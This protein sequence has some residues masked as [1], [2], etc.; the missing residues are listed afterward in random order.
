MIDEHAL[1]SI[2]IP[3]FD[4]PAAL[5][6]T[7]AGVGCP[8]DD[9]SLCSVLPRILARPHGTQPRCTQPVH[10][11]GFRVRCRP[12]I[13]SEPSPYPETSVKSVASWRSHF[14]VRL[15]NFFDESL[16]KFC[17][18]CFE[19]RPRGIR[20]GGRDGRGETRVIAYT[21]VHLNRLYFFGNL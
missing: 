14:C 10:Q 6:R 16:S 4:R 3:T 21:A 18:V 7:I 15:Y 12:A 1:C 11:D 20:G 19:Y 8:I 2:G 17:N 5:S 9:R 13:R